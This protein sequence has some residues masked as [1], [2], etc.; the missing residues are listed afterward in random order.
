MKAIDELKQRK[1]INWINYLTKTREKNINYEHLNSVKTISSKMVYEYIVRCFEILEKETNT[2]SNEIYDYICET[3]KWSDVAKVGSKVDRNKW[4]NKGYDLFV[5][6]IG[7][8]QIYAEESENYDEVIRVLIKTHG[9]IGQHI[10]G[11]VNLSKNKELY[12]LIEKGLITKEKLKST[13]VLL[14]KCVVGAVSL[15]LYDKIKDEILSCIDAIVNNRFN[16]EID[17]K[18]K[19]KRLNKNI[20]DNDLTILDN[21]KIKI[22]LIKVFDNLELWYYESA[23][24]D[25]NLLEQIKILL[26]ISN[27]IDNSTKQVTFENIMK[28]IYLDYDGKKMINIYKERIIEKMLDEM[29]IDSIISNN[30]KSNPHI[31]CMITKLG[32]TLLFNFNFSIQT[33]KLIEFC[34]VAYTTNSIYNKAVYMLYDLLGFRRDEYDRFY[35]EIDYLATMNLS[36]SNKKVLLN[37]LVGNNI[38]DVGPGGGALM[39]LIEESDPKYKVFGIDISS[40]VIDELNRK[41]INENRKW[42]LVKGDALNLESYFAINSIDTIIYSSIIHELYS[43]IN[44]NGKKFNIDTVIKTLISAYKIIPVGGRIVIRDGIKTEPENKYRIIEFR[45]KDDI[46]ILNNYCNDFKGRKVTYEELGNS[47]VKML[48]NDAM[49]F[50]YTYTWGENSYSLEVKEQFGYLTPSEYKKLILDNLPNS[51]IIECKAFLQDGYEENL[52]NKITIYDEFMN[53]AKLPNSTCIIV[54]EKLK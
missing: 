46:S 52:L 44:Y 38:L 23:L 17:I 4:L 15:I 21:K 26:I 49:E 41:K 30:V 53:I 25:F 12:E 31:E 16:S 2:V 13:L 27:Y 34:E 54:I 37:Y 14:N 28:T 43:Y 35:N 18:D 51:K 20:T 33:I 6:N 9:L 11:E 36:M 24:G 47:R 42:T 3:L 7:S 48:V 32:E 10:R 22:A 29:D 5:H 40:N 8:S 39:D 19:I 50:L 1:N 45:N